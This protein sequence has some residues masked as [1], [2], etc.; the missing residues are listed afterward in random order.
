[1]IPIHIRSSLRPVGESMSLAREGQWLEFGGVQSCPFFGHKHLSWKVHGCDC[2]M[3]IPNR[4]WPVMFGARFGDDFFVAWICNKRGGAGYVVAIFWSLSQLRRERWILEGF[5]MKNDIYQQYITIFFPSASKWPCCKVY[6]SPKKIQH[7]SPHEAGW[8]CWIS[9]P[10]F[11]ATMLSSRFR[12]NAFWVSMR[13]VFEILDRATILQGKGGSQWS[14]FFSGFLFLKSWDHGLYAVKIN[15][16]PSDTGTD[17][18][19]GI[20]MYAFSTGLRPQSPYA[21]V[22]TIH[23]GNV[24]WSYHWLFQETTAYWLCCVFK[25]VSNAFWNSD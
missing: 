7:D 16:Y 1:M 8:K 19:W 24:N 21:N 5:M 12:A 23:V 6:S 4:R 3:A 11:V 14:G 13:S 25:R 17:L 22:L 9:S 2:R 18:Y 10:P 20:S 15:C